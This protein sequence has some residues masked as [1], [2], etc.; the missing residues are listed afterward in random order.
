VPLLGLCQNVAVEVRRATAEDASAIAS[1]LREAFV[2][3]APLYTPDA[4]AATTPSAERILDRWHEGP[5][6][7]VEY[8][9]RIVGTVAAMPQDEALYVRSMAIVPAA[10]GRN[11][12]RL[13]LDAV[14]R[15]ARAHGFTKLCLST[16]RF[17]DRAIRLYEQSGFVRATSGPEALHGTP[18]V[19]MEKTLR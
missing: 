17:L 2:E 9:R 11:L 1:V 18:L 8:D 10:R 3:Y 6:W 4:L 19:T 12:G 14:E 16:T 5:V 13:L 15:F 7:V